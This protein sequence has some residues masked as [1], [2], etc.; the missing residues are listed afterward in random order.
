MPTPPP[1]AKTHRFDLST[2][3]KIEYK[4]PNDG[5][6]T[7]N[8]SSWDNG[9][10]W[11]NTST[12]SWREVSAEVVSISYNQSSP[13]L[14][15]YQNL[16]STNVMITLAG[17]TLNPD[18]QKLAYAGLPIKITIVDEAGGDNLF[19]YG[20]ISS[21][22]VNYLPGVN[23]NEIIIQA[24]DG[25]DNYL[26]TLLDVNLPAQTGYAR[27]QDVNTAMASLG[28]NE[29]FVNIS[30]T[31]YTFDA[32][33]GTYTVGEIL[34]P[35]LQFLRTNNLYTFTEDLGN[36]NLTILAVEGGGTADII[37]TDT[38]IQQNQTLRYF[39]L[40]SGNDNSLVYNQVKVTD[41]TDATVST[42]T[43]ADS[44]KLNGVNSVE[45]QTNV[46]LPATNG[47]TWADAVIADT[48]RKTYSNVGINPIDL[49]GYLSRW[50]LRIPFY[51]DFIL[52]MSLT[53]TMVTKTVTKTALEM[54]INA[55]GITFTI[56][57]AKPR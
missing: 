49:N 48:N 13:L 29:V 33:L 17:D 31:S 42:K 12:I 24:T 7:W 5:V 36:Y 39:S 21:Y 2:D 44:I 37:F 11:A 50:A 27:A 32:L 23:R 3:V 6:F 15:G 30:N 4:A 28:L 19:F 8:I 52:Q 35:V 46:T 55:N 34:T 54:N 45:F 18:I 16:V 22:D 41:S 14:D 25:L 26:N 57:L 51:F 47:A 38:E 40:T 53:G 9:D 56:E 20:R 43:A 10:K 1:V